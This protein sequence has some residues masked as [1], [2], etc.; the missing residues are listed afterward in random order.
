MEE[1]KTSEEFEDAVMPEEA[2]SDTPVPEEDE[3]VGE[4]EKAPVED[5]ESVVLR[6]RRHLTIRL[7]LPYCMQNREAVLSTATRCESHRFTDAFLSF[8][9][10]ACQPK[11]RFVP[12]IRQEKRKELH[13]MPQRIIF[14]PPIPH[15]VPRQS[16]FR[17]RN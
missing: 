16:D 9:R 12:P 1:L 5:W 17:A 15:A 11:R 14:A 2:V 4:E 8:V 6:Q 13:K 10:S 7:N 3:D